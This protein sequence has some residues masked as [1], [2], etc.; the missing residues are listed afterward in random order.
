MKTLHYGFVGCGMMG[1]EHIRNLQLI[2][3]CK[4]AAIFEPDA[5]MRAQAKMLV[6][7]AIEA[8]SLD[9]LLQIEALDALIITS[10]NFCHADQLRQIASTRTLPILCEKPLYTDPADAAIIRDLAASYHA[11]IWVGME[12]RYMPPVAA[13]I[14]KAPS[15][16]GDI[17]MLSITEHRFPFLAKVGDWNRFNTQSGGTFVEKCCHFFDLMRLIIPAE[18]SFVMSIAGQAHNHLDENYDGKV[19]DI[20][21]HGYVI[22]EF[23]NQARAMLELCMFAE[24]SAYQ[25]RISAIGADGKAEAFVPSAARFW[26]DELSTLPRPKLE[27]SPR[28]R[29]QNETIYCDVDETLMIAG[30]HA[31]STY[32]QHLEFKKTI[33]EKLAPAVSL[34]D[35]MKAVKMG[36][37][38]QI[39]ASEKRLVFMD[40]L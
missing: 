23:E 6:S 16:C 4:I 31:G 7:D 38:A 3:G 9:A 10:P 32:Y 35:G 8:S 22:V 15:F 36:Q 20:W 1:Q 34:D 40:E 11:P 17:R 14:Q 33:T 24:G 28:A 12:Y 37:A 21:D 30:D 29:K 26:P 18:P 2:D 27:L 13:L 25:E 19:P 5:D 39:S